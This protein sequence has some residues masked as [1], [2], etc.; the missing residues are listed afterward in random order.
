MEHRLGSLWF[1]EKC[2]HPGSIIQS[3]SCRTSGED[4]PL[5][6]NPVKFQDRALLSTAADPL[7]SAIPQ[8]PM[9]NALVKTQMSAEIGQSDPNH[10]FIHIVDMVSWLA[11]FGRFTFQGSDN[12][13][14]LF[15]R[16]VLVELYRTATS[17]EALL[18]RG[19]GRNR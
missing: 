15:W 16:A 2:V 6:G 4:H 19:S 1:C 17:E 8:R 10:Q 13:S 12:D 14:A 7:C 5:R 9:G 3:M 18:K 11:K